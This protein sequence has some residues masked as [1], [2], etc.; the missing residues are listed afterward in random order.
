MAKHIDINGVEL[1]DGTR[2]VQID[3]NNAVAIE[4]GHLVLSLEDS[5]SEVEIENSKE[6]VEILAKA[7]AR[8][9]SIM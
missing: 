3:E 9:A 8:L 2:V 6:Y 7:L 4:N 5:V 1:D